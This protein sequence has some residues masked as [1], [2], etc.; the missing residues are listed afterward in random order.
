[1]STGLNEALLQHAQELLP[2]LTEVRR[3]FHR[4]PE[5]GMEEFRTQ[6]KISAY[7]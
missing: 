6:E 7:L 2:W 3:D 5:F 1:M 4:Y